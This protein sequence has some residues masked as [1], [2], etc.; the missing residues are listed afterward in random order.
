MIAKEGLDYELG[1]AVEMRRQG[2]F[3]LLHD[4]TN[5]LRIADL[6]EFHP[7]GMKLLYEIKKNPSAK[8]GPQRRRMAQPLKLP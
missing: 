6:T 7:D 1:A 3:G 4:L 8:R 2:R 5:C